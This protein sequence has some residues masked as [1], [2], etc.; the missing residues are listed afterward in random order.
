MNSINDPE[1]DYQRMTVLVK[2]VRD[3]DEN[4]SY[5]YPPTRAEALL[6]AWALPE[7]WEQ[8]RRLVRAEDELTG[9]Q[10]DALE[11][12]LAI[13]PKPPVRLSIVPS[14]Q[15][16]EPGDPAA[17]DFLSL[18]PDQFRAAFYALWALGWVET[19]AA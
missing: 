10:F 19:T 15:A 13:Y 6:V 7:H 2:I 17:D 8:A 1:Y 16:D 3:K 11:R 12:L 18:P 4:G 9:G 5:P 14:S